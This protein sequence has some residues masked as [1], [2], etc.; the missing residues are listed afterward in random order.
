[1]AASTARTFINALGAAALLAAVTIGATPRPAGAQEISSNR[2]NTVVNEQGCS[3]HYLI[4]VPGGANTVEGLP[5]AIPHGGNV[6]STGL[7]VEAQTHG[8]VE[9]LWVSYRSLPF[10][11][12]TYPA[13]FDDGYRETRNAVTTLAQ[14]CPE[15]RFSFTGYSLGAHITSQMTSDIAHGRGPIGPERV[16]SVALFSNPH[17]GGNGAVLSPG[18]P[19]DSRGAL[20]SLPEGYGEL[21][22]RVLEICHADDVVCSMPPSLRGLVA[23]AMQVGLASGLAPLAP[24]AHVLATLGLDVFKLAAGIT[25]HGGYEGPDRREAAGW[26]TAHA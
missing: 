17:Q 1:M 14:R 4:A 9:A 19:P 11:V 16:G 12:D 20:G 23:P 22:P 13:A 6:F 24:V 15:A 21:G 8:A 7:I 5:T 2:A 18:T 26:I 3:A 10:A 25:A